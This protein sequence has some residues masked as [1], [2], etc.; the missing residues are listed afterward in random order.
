MDQTNTI[1]ATRRAVAAARAA[2]RTIG[3]VPTMGGLHAGHRSL[4]ERASRDGHFVVLSIFV[5]PTQFGPGEDYRGYPR[6]PDADAALARSAGC[7]LVFAPTVEEMYGPRDET[8]VRPGRLAEGLCGAFRPGH[9]E[10]VCTVVA[11]L[12]LIV[13]P[14]VAY[15]GQ[16]DAQ[17]AAIV[18]AMADD[19]KFPL[20]IEVCPIVR[21]PDGLAC[22]TRNAYLAPEHRAQAA[23]LHRALCAGR[24]LLASGERRSGLILLEMRRVL[25]AAGSCKVDYLAIVDPHTLVDVSDV[26]GRVMLALAVRI[27][28]ARLIDNLLVDAGP[29]SPK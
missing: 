15:F 3:Y 27:G 19:L 17:Q 18:R 13:Q 7:D 21:E 8:R 28:G 29:P 14:D 6:D 16:K 11:R 24:D 10:G 12:F 2:A 25:D 26:Q 23:S 20:R 9:F 4:I 1:E 22:S 5:N